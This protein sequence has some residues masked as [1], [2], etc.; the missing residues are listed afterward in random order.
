MLE[1]GP[2]GHPVTP[3]RP[4]GQAD[5]TR[6]RCQSAGVW[7]AAGTK[8]SALQDSGLGTGKAGCGRTGVQGEGGAGIVGVCRWTWERVPEFV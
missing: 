6:L 5:S 8:A 3:T 7:Q 2:P 1:W 4:R